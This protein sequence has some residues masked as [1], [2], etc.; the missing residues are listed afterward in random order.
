M[1]RVSTPFLPNRSR[2]SLQHP[3]LR[4]HD[5][6]HAFQHLFFLTEVATLAIATTPNYNKLPLWF[7]HLF[8]LTEV[9]TGFNYERD[10]WQFIVSTPFLPNR[11]RYHIIE[12]K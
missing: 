4:G 12:L 10:N 2:Y 11:S 7:Q 1:L 9:A 6:L 3:N 5:T 8:F